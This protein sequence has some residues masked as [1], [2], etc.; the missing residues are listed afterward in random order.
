MFIFFNLYFFEVLFAIL[1]IPFHILP[2]FDITE[3]AKMIILHQNVANGLT[4][5]Q[6]SQ[7]FE[8]TDTTRLITHLVKFLR[9]L[10]KIKADKNFLKRGE[11]NVIIFT[12]SISIFQP[13]AL[14]DVRITGLSLRSRTCIK[15]TQHINKHLYHIIILYR[16]FTSIS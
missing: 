4:K 9:K 13:L 2:Q 12:H 14:V 3:N 1:K 11:V 5:K 16:L 7:F 10:S 6:V 8:I 15:L